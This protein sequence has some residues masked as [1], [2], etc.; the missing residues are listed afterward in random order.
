MKHVKII[1][2]E[3]RGNLVRFYLGK[4]DLEDWYGDDW[5]DA[6]YEH[7]AGVVYDEFVS[8]VQDIVF[9][10]DMC[11]LEPRDEWRY[12]GNSPYSKDDFKARSAPCIVVAKND[13]EWMR[14]EYTDALA[15]KD[16]VRFYYGDPME[17]G[18]VQIYGKK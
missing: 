7:N 11:V 15:R 17:P 12:N 5:D 4:D 3:K 2:F 1:D 13:Y 16:S 14:N 18:E 6:P 9:P 8:G 10:F